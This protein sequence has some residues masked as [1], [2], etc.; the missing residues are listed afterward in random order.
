MIIA[1]QGSQAVTKTTESPSSE[2][3][4]SSNSCSTQRSTD[5]LPQQFQILTYSAQAQL[6]S[7]KRLGFPGGAGMPDWRES[8]DVGQAWRSGKWF[9]VAMTTCYSID[10]DSQQVLCYLDKGGSSLA[11]QNVL[12]A[13]GTD[14]IQSVADQSCDL[15]L[16][17]KGSLLCSFLAFMSQWLCGY[18]DS[19]VCLSWLSRDKSHPECQAGLY[20]LHCRLIKCR[21]LG[22]V[23]SGTLL[24]PTRTLWIFSCG[25]CSFLRSMILA[26]RGSKSSSL[27]KIACSLFQGLSRRG[28]LEDKRRQELSQQQV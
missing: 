8:C 27:Q 5:G 28:L 21:L 9:S 17:A 16:D 12:T 1:L 22:E 3:Q 24:G 2:R 4:A 20:G 18:P 13:S 11:A 19:N 10:N 6:D 25:R 15:R 23:C 14:S 7:K 26:V